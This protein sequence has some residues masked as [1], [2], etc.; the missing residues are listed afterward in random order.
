[1]D[2]LAH[3]VGQVFQIGL[4]F[5]GHDDGFEAGAVCGEHFFFD[6]AHGQ[7]LTAQGDFARHAH[8]GLDRAAGEQRDQR[9]SHSHAR[10]GA[11]FGL[12]A[13][14]HMQVDVGLFKK[15]LR[16]APFRRPRTDV[17]KC[18]ARGFLHHLAQ[19]A[20]ED[21]AL[22]AG[23]FGR[24]NEEDVAA[25]GRPRQADGHAGDGHPPRHILQPVVARPPQKFA[26]LFGRDFHRRRLA[27]RDLAH[28]FAANFA[29][30]PLKVAHARLARV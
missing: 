15:V 24:L 18:G 6:A 22:V 5:F 7:H 25:R 10:G 2:S 17:G 23:H 12:R 16:N 3:F 14:G 9:G 21:E 4:I 26:H 28:H 13:R 1:M 11:V 8:F 27:L 20:G 19:R 29:N 30:F